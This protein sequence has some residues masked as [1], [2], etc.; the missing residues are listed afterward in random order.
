MTFTP[1]PEAE[2]KYP[3]GFR[4]LDGLRHRK[5]DAK[6]MDFNNTNG[7]FLFYYY[8][9]YLILPILTLPCHSYRCKHP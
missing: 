9:L 6:R 7:E 3:E 4:L 5:S 2:E 1:I 8:L